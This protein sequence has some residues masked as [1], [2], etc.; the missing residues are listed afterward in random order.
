MNPTT[1]RKVRNFAIEM[2]IYSILVAGYLF[3]VIRYLTGWLTELFDSNL[4]AYAIVALVFI[5]AQSVFLDSLTSFLMDRL[6]L[7]RLD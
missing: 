2:L 4:T 7:Q 5:V 3:F 1:R 6:G